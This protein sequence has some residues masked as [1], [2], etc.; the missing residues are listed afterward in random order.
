M[1]ELLLNELKDESNAK[2][3]R[4]ESIRNAHNNVKKEE[5]VEERTDRM[6][7]YLEVIYELVPAERLCYHY[8]YFK[9][10]QCQFSKCH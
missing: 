3:H 7:D 1:N 10:S 5:G 2:N 8:R 6:E 4:L 9:M